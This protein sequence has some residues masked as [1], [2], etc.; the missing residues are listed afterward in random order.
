MAKPVIVPAKSVA[1]MQVAAASL[2]ASSGVWKHFMITSTNGSQ[3]T[4]LA[5]WKCYE[6]GVG[7]SVVR[8]SAFG[9][10]SGTSKIGYD[11][12]DDPANCRLD[13]IRIFGEVL[14]SSDN[15]ALYASG[16]G[17]GISA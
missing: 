4:T 11:G 8:S 16:A 5:H 13:D 6:N 7:L 12:A 17:R 3:S 1:V 9:T 10:F 15:A 2:A 14:N